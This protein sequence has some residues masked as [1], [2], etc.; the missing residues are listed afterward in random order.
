MPLQKR[1]R[2]PL[3]LVGG[4]RSYGVAEKLVTEKIADYV[5]LCRPLIREPN[6]I[7]RWKSG[8]TRKATCLSDNLCFNPTRAGEGLR[9]MVEPE[10]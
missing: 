8:D 9:C 2:V 7:N 6:L 10:V 1:V 4:I 3:V 5:S